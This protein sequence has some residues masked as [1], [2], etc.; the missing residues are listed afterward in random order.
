LYSGE[1]EDA[2]L[3]SEALQRAQ[4]EI[5]RVSRITKNNLKLAAM[6]SSGEKMTALDFSALLKSGAEVRRRLVEKNN[7]ALVANVPDDLPKVYGNADQLVQV[8]SNL[9]DNANRHTKYGKIS[10]KADV[11][12][13]LVI[14]KVLDNGMGIPAELLPHI[15]ERGVSNAI[16]TGIGLPICKQIVEAHGGTISAQS[17]KGKGTAITIKLPIHNEDRESAENV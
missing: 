10:I 4:V 1:G 8:L 15:F 12:E 7:N 9:I 13:G 5:L 14:T 2:K 11:N 6:Q 3:I 17:E 16:S